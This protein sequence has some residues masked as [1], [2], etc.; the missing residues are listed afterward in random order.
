[1][2]Y[3]LMYLAVRYHNVCILQMVQLRHVSACECGHIANQRGRE[4]GRE[5]RCS[6]C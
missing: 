5:G 1:M 3:V 6:K 2:R 4:R